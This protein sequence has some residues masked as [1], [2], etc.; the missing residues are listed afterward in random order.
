[1]RRAVNG[2]WR[3]K[4]RVSW[5]W[6]LGWLN[7]IVEFRDKPRGLMW[8][9]PP[10]QPRFLLCPVFATN[11]WSL[12]SHTL[13]ML[14]CTTVP[15]HVFIFTWN[16]HCHNW[17]KSTFMQC[18]MLAHRESQKRPLEGKLA[19][20]S[21]QHRFCVSEEGGAGQLSGRFFFPF[22]GRNKLLT[23]FLGA[24]LSSASM[25]MGLPCMSRSHWNWPP[26]SWAMFW[27]AS[28]SFLFPELSVS[29]RWDAAGLCQWLL[30]AARD[31]LR[32]LCLLLLFR[33]GQESLNSCWH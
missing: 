10:S 3:P 27:S 18:Q 5:H 25:T 4:C 30:T 16:V 13:T 7:R 22:E 19:W 32:A 6:E 9:L 31:P 14:F 28:P 8:P 26:T 12:E 11:P 20:A 33:H 17:W 1:M 2:G 15:L 21:S 24:V 29:P 23:A